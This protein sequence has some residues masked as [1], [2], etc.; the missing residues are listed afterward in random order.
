M[1]VSIT[2]VFASLSLIFQ[3]I[4]SVTAKRIDL[5]VVS[6]LTFMYESYSKKLGV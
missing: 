3:I 4:L 5:L 2:N 1:D 6:A